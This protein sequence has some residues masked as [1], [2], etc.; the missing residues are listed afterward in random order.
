MSAATAKLGSL[1][2]PAFSRPQ[3]ARCT[4]TPAFSP[5][6]ARRLASKSF[7]GN[8]SALLPAF[9]GAFS[10]LSV[11]SV[12]AMA[13]STEQATFAAVRRKFFVDL[14]YDELMKRFQGCSVR[15]QK[16]AHLLDSVCL[17]LLVSS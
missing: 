2:T 9:V 17:V 10:L 3:L 16:R 6:N 4:R 15:G 11:R 5:C 12:A 13:S 8:R 7:T 14:Q 1:V